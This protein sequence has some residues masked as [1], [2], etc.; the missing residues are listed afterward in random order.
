MSVCTWVCALRDELHN[1][2]PLKFQLTFLD[3][4]YTH[5][6]SKIRNKSLNDDKARTIKKTSRV[7]AAKKLKM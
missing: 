3:M 7:L 2:Q 6:H 1:A 5:T 4:F